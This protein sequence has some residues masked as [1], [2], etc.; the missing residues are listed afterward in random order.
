MQSMGT[1]DWLRGRGMS[2]ADG[3]VALFSPQLADERQSAVLGHVS[4]AALSLVI[5]LNYCAAVAFLLVPGSRFEPCA[6]VFLGIALGARVLTAAA[7]R[8]QGVDLRIAVQMPT[9]G[10]IVLS[11]IGFGAGS[12]AV[13]RFIP[14]TEHASWHSN[15]LAGAVAALIWA[16]LI[17]RGLNQKPKA[18]LPAEGTTIGDGDD[19]PDA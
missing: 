9:R 15:L 3:V 12:V 1:P 19:S 2:W 14:G 5:W 11:S 16:F 10:G 8:W 4:A 6:W 7:A 13:G 17:T 18:A